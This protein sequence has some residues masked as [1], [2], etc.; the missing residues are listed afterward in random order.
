MVFMVAGVGLAIDKGGGS[1][2]PN[3]PEGSNRMITIK[4]GEYTVFNIN[5]FSQL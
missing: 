2:N 3:V 4:N 1:V 5:N